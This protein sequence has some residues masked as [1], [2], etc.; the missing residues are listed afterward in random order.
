MYI[1]YILS[2]HSFRNTSK[3]FNLAKVNCTS[4][5]LYGESKL[6]FHHNKCTEVEFSREY[7]RIRKSIQVY[8]CKGELFTSVV[9]YIST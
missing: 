3:R 6:V 1:T 2:G 9:Q 7:L 5:I 8:P 4:N